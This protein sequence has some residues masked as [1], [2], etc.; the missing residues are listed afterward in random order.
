MDT[1]AALISIFVGL[2]AGKFLFRLLFD[3]I[4]EF[5]ECVGYSLTPD[6]FSLFRGELFRDMEKS[7]KLSL[8]TLL[9]IGAGA[10]TYFGITKLL[11]VFI[12]G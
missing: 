11:E 5:W 9:T 3:D 6:I 2:F 10:L 7:M 12:Q 4:D 1:A 8:F